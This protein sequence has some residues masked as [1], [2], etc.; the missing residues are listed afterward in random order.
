M[1][2][3]N[4]LIAGERL[5]DEAGSDLFTRT[6][7]QATATL[8]NLLASKAAKL[9][10][11]SWLFASLKLP[12]LGFYFVAS[13][14]TRQSRTSAALHA[15]ILAAGLVTVG[16]QFLLPPPEAKDGI[17]SGVIGFGW[18]MLAYGL[19]LSTVQA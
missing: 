7:A 11:V 6:L 16:I 2:L 8:Q 9:G 12:V 3:Q 14:L 4:G 15:G 10:P 19:L 13:T 17:P 18:A 5:V 1:S